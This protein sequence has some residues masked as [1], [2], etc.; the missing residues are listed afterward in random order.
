M[1]KRWVIVGI[2]IC[3]FHSGFYGSLRVAAA[4]ESEK[5]WVSKVVSIQGNVFAKRVDVA[6]WQP[7]R[8]DDTLFAGDRIRVEA[9]SRAGILLSNDA[10]LRLDQNTTL[11]FTGVE[12]ETTFILKLLK[13]AA[14]FFSHRPRS[15][16]IVTPF[17][18]GVV[19]GTEFYVQVDDAQTRIDLFEGRILA[20][21]PHG[22]VRLAK[23]QQVTASAVSAPQRQVLV[24]PRDSVQWALYYPPVMAFG[25]GEG[26]PALRPSFE[27]TE[28]GR[29]SE[30]IDRL[31]RTAPRNRDA[32]FLVYRAALLLNVG[33]VNEARTDIREVLTLEPQNSEALALQAVIAVVQ[34]RKTDALQSAREAVGAD[35]RSTAALI[36]LSYALQAEF[37][38][39]EALQAAQQAVEQ[40]PE[41]ATAQARL[42]ELRLSVGELNQGIQAAQKAAELDPHSAHAH[43]ILGFAYLTQIKTERA[44]QAFNQAITMDSAA[45]LPR[46]G[47]GLARIRDG[48]L[49]P[50][51]SQIEIAVGLDPANALMRSYLGKAYFDEKRGPMDEEQ[52]KIAKTLDPNDPTPWFYDAIRKQT[53]NRPVEALQDLQKSIELNDNRAVYRSRLM[54]D[55]DLAARSAS[56][57]RIYNDLGFQELA[58]RQGWRSLNTDP[59]NYSAHRLLADTYISRPRYEIA[60]VSELLQSKLLQPL[61]I[62][63]D[64]PQMEESFILADEGT[65]WGTSSLNEYNPLFTRNRIAAQLSGLAGNNETWGDEIAI[66]G[67]YDQFAL[68]IG[69]FRY[70]SNGFREN[71]DIDQTIYSAFFQ[72]ALT[73]KVNF[74]VE[75]RQKQLDHG[76][77][78]VYWDLFESGEDYRLKMDTD[79]WRAGMHINPAKHSDIIASII[80]QDMESDEN[81]Y[82]SPFFPNYY[83]GYKTKGVME[84]IQYLYRS[85]RVSFIFGGGHFDTNNKLIYNNLFTEDF[86]VKH[87][88]GY[89]YSHI[90]FPRNL[91]WIIGASYDMVDDEQVGDPE[92]FNPKFGFTWQLTPATTLRAAAFRVLK[93]SLLVDQ[94][95][96]PTQVAGFN[97]FFDDWNGTGGTVY[98]A[99]VDQRFFNSLSGGVEFMK[100]LMK[101]PRVLLDRVLEED[102][103]DDTLRAYLSWS[104][105]HN[106]ALN[107]EY[108]FELFERE[109]GDP[110]EAAPIKM[111]AH[112]APVTLGYFHSSGISGRVKL[113]YVHQEVNLPAQ[114]DETETEDFT[115]TDIAL[116]YR[117]PGRYGIV[118][119]E[120]RNVFDKSFNYLGP[121]VRS[122]Q[123]E[124]YPDFI[125]ER[126]F[127]VR[128]SLSF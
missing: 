18:N 29:L 110:Y 114:P 53:L 75:Y 11:V 56:L 13:G 80:Y 12:R 43:T 10:V 120:I 119:A 97:Q 79:I 17:V 76:N 46:L 30:A 93:R 89:V 108:A 123:K 34:N 85:P 90:R 45:P 81:F 57:G 24:R 84:E 35:P 72:T 91:N 21:N 9:N 38:L 60:R 95:I 14:N 26:P 58:L 115:T 121:D 106:V 100:R 87:N 88:N 67:L 66:S 44:R 48:N 37:K 47:L 28:Q 103:D 15:L 23:G 33:R 99:A 77:L 62:N 31:E 63:P 118:S 41:N 51:R 112:I 126:T 113:S 1:K 68:S 7:L 128:L 61:N 40:G 42:A 73:P 117:I 83:Y 6:G 78:S 16:K 55:D 25:P 22:E 39:E 71:N 65:G 70:E 109:V 32:Q 111:E 102:W 82:L 8:L 54:L 4:G 127:L 92:Q 74:Q 125:P 94:T 52:L 101:K 124:F 69:Q 3:L 122:P 96:E 27:L 19:E 104:I 36:A 59:A 105:N 64:Q 50:G 2:L 98:A 86:D 107:S 5:E 20:Q 49:E 116:G